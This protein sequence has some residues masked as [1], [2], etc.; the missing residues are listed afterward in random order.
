MIASESPVVGEWGGC[1]CISEMYVNELTIGILSNAVI[2]ELVN[3]PNVSDKGYFCIYFIFSYLVF[4]FDYHQF[5]EFLCVF[6]RVGD[7]RAYGLK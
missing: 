4:C 7:V 3:L 5:W 1:W 6:Y 2:L